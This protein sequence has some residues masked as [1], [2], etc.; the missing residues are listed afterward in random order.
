MTESVAQQRTSLRSFFVVWAGQL[1]S[2]TGT[3]MS[4]FGLQLFVYSETG[5]VTRLTFVA[6][7]ATL[8]AVVLAPVA[9]SVA[10]RLNRRLVM[11]ASD[12]LGGLAT[13]TL[14]WLYA[15]GNLEIWHIYV[16]ALAGSIANTFQD[17]AWQASIPV[18]VPKARLARA[19]GL[20]QLNQGVSIVLAPALA[21]ALLATLGL[22]AVLITDAVTFLAGIGTLALVRFPPFHATETGRRSVR[23]DARYAW[24]Y[25]RERPGLF[26]L[27]WVYS[28]VN[29]MLSMTNVL[30][31]PLIVSFSTEAAAG[32]IL[33]LAGAGAV[34]GSVAVGA[35]GVPKRLLPTIMGG[36]FISGILLIAGGSRASLIVVGVASVLLLLLNPI[37]NSA[38]QVIWQT[39]VAEGVQGR[40]FSL[41]RMIA[42]AVSP[43]A[44]LLAGPLSDHVFE[45][46]LAADGA[47]AGS[48]GAVIGVGP[49]RGIGLLYIVAGIG[50][51]GL[52]TLGWSRGHVRNI[53]TEL[54]DLAGRE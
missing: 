35:L 33:S 54:P 11:M 12:S 52:A 1:V 51:M 24:R 19:N 42:Q 48:V 5:S 20:V 23:D 30:I 41:R 39:K 46:L 31:I 44:V 28:G 40:V 45:P 17:P 18:L 53:E 27:L 43:L 7:A 6:L 9:G 38:S 29:F 15:T 49:G 13:M 22:G 8:P 2:I 34:I 32:T 25:L 16:A 3:T 14:F 37:V 36:I 4:A 47:L 10:D 26:G 50:T 21:G